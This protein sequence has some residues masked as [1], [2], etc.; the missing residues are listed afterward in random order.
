MNNASP[1][2]ADVA[3]KKFREYWWEVLP[4]G[5]YS[6][7]STRLQLIPK[8]KITYVGMTLFLLWKSILLALHKLFDTEIKVVS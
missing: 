5:T 4:L 6:P 7:E 8:V 1:H 2:I 3:T